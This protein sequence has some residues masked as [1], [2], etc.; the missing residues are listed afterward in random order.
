MV[1]GDICVCSSSVSTSASLSSITCKAS[2]A[3]T[4][5]KR[6]FTS[7]LTITSVS[8]RFGCAILS[9]KWAEFLIYVLSYSHPHSSEREKRFV[10]QE[11]SPLR[12]K[13]AADEN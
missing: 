8:W 6:L 10:H 3:G 13:D 9:T 4:R 7:K 12:R 11:L 5:V 1:V 2:W